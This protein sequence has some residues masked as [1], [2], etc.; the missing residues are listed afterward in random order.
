MGP[1]FIALA[2]LCMCAFSL[3]KLRFLRAKNYV[4][5]QSIQ[6]LKQGRH[7]NICQVPDSLFIF[8]F[9]GTT[10]LWLWPRDATLCR[11]ASSLLSNSTG[12][13]TAFSTS[14][15]SWKFKE[16]ILLPEQTMCQS[17]VL[18]GIKCLL[19]NRQKRIALRNI[20]FES[21]NTWSGMSRQRKTGFL[22]F[23]ELIPS[24]VLCL[25]WWDHIWK[26]LLINIST[27]REE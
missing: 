23:S 6:W 22:S 21:H 3:T 20:P 7:S 8:F 13:S 26:D 10:P 5:S 4:S 27:F 18:P 19:R 14:S 9:S 15:L 2:L 25:V 1:L 12:F 16:T 24:G 17:K 11:I